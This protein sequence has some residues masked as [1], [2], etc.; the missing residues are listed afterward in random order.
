[1]TVSSRRLPADRARNGHVRPGLLFEDRLLGHPGLPGAP[2]YL[3]KGSPLVSLIRCCGFCELLAGV[4]AIIGLVII[5]GIL[6]ASWPLSLMASGAAL[7]AAG[8]AA[9]VGTQAGVSWATQRRREIEA[10]EHSHRETVYEELLTHMTEVFTPG[11]SK[12]PEAVVRS[13]VALWGSEETL[14]APADGHTTGCV[15]RRGET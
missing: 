12:T 2:A 4:V 6:P 14:E 9:L 3:G 15:Q 7:L 11:G 13:K 5:V 8:L 1:M 10:S